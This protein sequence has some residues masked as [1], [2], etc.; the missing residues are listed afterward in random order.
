MLNGQGHSDD[1]MDGLFKCVWGHGGLDGCLSRTLWQVKFVLGVL[2]AVL[3]GN[4]SVG[5]TFNT[6]GAVPKQE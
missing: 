2:I 6:A 3:S 5:D 4:P 1:P